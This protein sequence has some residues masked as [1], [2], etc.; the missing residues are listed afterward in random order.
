[1]RKLC[2]FRVLLLAGFMGIALVCS[3]CSA[4]TESDVRRND[5][6]IAADTYVEETIRIAEETE[7]SGFMLPEFTEEVLLCSPEAKFAFDGTIS[8]GEAKKVG[9]PYRPFVFSYRFTEDSGVLRIGETQ[10]LTDALQYVLDRERTSLEIHN[11]KVNTEYFYTVEVNGC[12]YTGS[13]FTADSPRFVHM[14]GAVNVRDIGGQKNLDGIRIKQG[15]LIRG[16]EIDGIC[17]TEYFVKD[18]DLEE[19]KAGFSFAYDFDLREENV[20]ISNYQSRI[21]QNQKHRFHESPEYGEIFQNYYKQRLR[22]IFVD[23]ADPEHYPMYLH[24]TYGADRTGT[25]VFLLQGIL[26]MSEEDMYREYMLS[27]YEFDKCLDA[28][29]LDV[30]VTGLAGTPGDTLQQKIVNYLTG[31]VGVKQEHIASIR[32]IFLEQSLEK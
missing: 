28:T 18:Q 1:M 26:N 21:A 20:F 13:F 2:S 31:K 7:P 25:V 3:G 4:K 22:Q 5:E 24:C 19:A 15:L 6:E 16:S 9:D 17:E 11:L 27:G 10:D 14:P 23:L 8:V 30:I 12:V 29:G 32:S